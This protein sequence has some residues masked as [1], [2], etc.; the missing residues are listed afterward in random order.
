MKN[1][2][3]DLPRGQ[4]IVITGPSGS[5][6]SS[7][8]FDTLFAEGQRRYVESLS[9][10][11][12]Q[13]LERMDRP[14]VDEIQGISPAMAI[15]QKNTFRTYRS[16]VGTATEVLD[17]IRLLFA[18]IGQTVC[19]ECGGEVKKDRVEDVVD[20][21]THLPPETR[22]LI[23]FP[24]SHD[25]KDPMRDTQ[26]LLSEGFVRLYIDGRTIRLEEIEDVDL[27]EKEVYVV[28]DRLMVGSGVRERVFDAV[29]TSFSHGRGEA[30]AIIEGAEPLR[31]SQHFNCERCGRTFIEPQP[32]LFSF[33]NPFGACPACRGFGDIMGIDLDLVVPDKT[34]SIREGAIE[35]WN[36]PTHRHI[37]RRLERV[38]SEYHL[39]LDTPYQDLTADQIE[40]LKYGDGYFPGIYRFFDWLETKKYKIGVRVFLSRYRGYYRCADCGGTR[41]RPEARWVLLG[42]KD[43]GEITRMTITQARGF[44]QNLTLTSYQEEVARQ[45]LRELRD[46]LEYL[47]E[48]GLDYL[49]LDRRSATLSGGEAQRINLATALGSRL[50]GSLYILDE[51]TVGLHPRDD[52]KLI[53]ILHMLR[54]L[55]NTVVVVEHDRA[56]MEAGDQILELGPRSGEQGGEVVYQGSFDGLQEDGCSLTGAYISGRK[57]I[58]VPKKRR[59][60]NGAMLT[61]VGVDE[62][63]LKSI[64]VEIPLGCFI[65]VTG[66]SGSGKSSLV[67]DVL[68]PALKLKKGAWKK[69]VGAYRDVFGDEHIDDVVLVDQS[70]IGRTPRSNAVT[71]V[72]GFDGIRRLFAKSRQAKV[73]GYSPGTF[74]FNVPGGRCEEC[75]GN[76]Q[77]QVEMVFLADVTIPCDV[78]GG[79]RFKKE[80]LEVE[81]QGKNIDD[82]LRMSVNEALEFFK[83]DSVIIR[84]LRILDDVGLGYLR[85][86]QPATTLSGGEAQRVKLAAHLAQKPGKRILY[87]FDEPTTGLHFDDIAN[88]LRC[89]DQLIETGNTVLVIE[90]NMDV[91]KCADWIID[92]GPEGGDEGGY[93]VAQ[94]TPEQVELCEESYTGQFLNKV[95]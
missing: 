13:F 63:N 54:D 25:D 80:V 55:G 32:R 19:P 93:I 48:V 11:A 58:P 22:F 92:L 76:G 18:R 21:V 39:S 14:D 7:L 23:C 27:K 59:A 20:A 66:V 34:K 44:F 52:V 74:S 62:H 91:I 10:Y 33:N 57:T 45:L 82:V 12:R 89:F 71:Y 9:A 49:T 24:L 83:D 4:M 68:Y 79:K 47:E 64:D 1:I 88:L 38:A 86:G 78:C 94:G 85:L 53:R 81:Y 60:G 2:D 95:L 3:V 29:E 5:G 30:V 31:F 50:V 67:E 65:I 40:L 77:I 28:I 69:R 26:E 61:L 73:R 90:H 8:A 42:G 35:P 37:L 56:M 51:P 6:K 72:K 43:I 36:T 15:E 17:Y 87:L 84:K 41:L 75:Q 70:P 46:R 16:T